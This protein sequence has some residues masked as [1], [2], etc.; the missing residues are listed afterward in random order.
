MSSWSLKRRRLAAPLLGVALLS[1]ACSPNDP[2]D[3]ATGFEAEQQ[4][5][6][7]QNP[8]PEPEY[9]DDD[10]VRLP[11][12]VV[13]PPGHN[14][15]ARIGE[16]GSIVENQGAGAQTNGP[17]PHQTEI[18]RTGAFGC[19]DTISVIQTVPTV[20]DDPA[21]A[22]LEYLLSMDSVSHGEPAFS[23][24]LA[25]SDDVSVASVERSDDQVTV[26]LEG[27]P[28]AR[29]SC[30]TWRVAKQIETTARIATGADHVEIRLESSTLNEHWGLGE[31][32]PLQITEI[33]RD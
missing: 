8:I 10:S 32:G 18:A 12:G 28:A 26:T 22:A 23:N 3:D 7:Q 16:D 27:E 17:L 25:L 29:D 5:Q 4:E 31:E 1:A 30:E 14:E 33:Q 6:T 19:G 11:I 20:V 15:I 9:D 13:S 21:E 24:P 2:E